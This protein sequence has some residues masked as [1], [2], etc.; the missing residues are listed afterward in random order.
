MSI[1]IKINQVQLSKIIESRE[2]LGTL[3]GKLAFH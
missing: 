1:D 2:F 3:L